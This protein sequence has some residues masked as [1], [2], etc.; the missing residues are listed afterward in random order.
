MVGL[1]DLKSG[2]AL[3]I[4]FMCAL[5]G[6]NKRCRFS[7]IAKESVPVTL[8]TGSFGFICPGFEIFV[9]E[10]SASTPI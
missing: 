3:R 9:S 6:N 8:S 10:I 5:L 4:G 7:N 1:V 2:L